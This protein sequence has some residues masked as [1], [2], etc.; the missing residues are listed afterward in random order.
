MTRS[1]EIIERIENHPR[2]V[3]DERTVMP[4]DKEN[5]KNANKTERESKSESSSVDERK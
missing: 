1:E 3:W 5:M 4:S 2:L